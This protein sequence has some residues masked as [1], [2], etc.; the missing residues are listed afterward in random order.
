MSDYLLSTRAFVALVRRHGDD[1]VLRWARTLELHRDALLLSAV[2]VGQV[3]E[4]IAALP[5]RAAARP[6]WQKNFDAALREIERRGRVLDF[7]ARCALR[8]AELE[9]LALQHHHETSG[10]RVELPTPARQVVA[11]CLARELPL[12]ETAQPYHRVLAR[13][14]GLLVVDPAA[15]ATA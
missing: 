8:W 9:P 11:Q 6:T 3:Q 5:A 4:A 10:E 12:V 13:R 1:P 2:S 14:Q 7:T 15:T